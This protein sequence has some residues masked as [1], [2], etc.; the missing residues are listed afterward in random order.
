MFWRKM[1]FV[2]AAIVG[3]A[4]GLGVTDASARGGRGGGGRG[5][6]GFVRGGRGRG[7]GWGIGLGAVGVGVAATC[8][9]SVYVNTP[10]GPRWRRVWVCN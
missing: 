6:R 4:I 7:I 2:I 9:R 5:G 10:Y 1:L 8:W 3:V